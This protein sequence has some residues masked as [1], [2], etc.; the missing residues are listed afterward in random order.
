MTTEATAPSELEGA[1]ALLFGEYRESAQA[2]AD[3]LASSAVERGLIGPREVP[4]LWARHL[5]NCAAI[6]PLIPAGSSMVDVGS[7]AG[8][9]G[10]V[11]AIIRPDVSV[12]LLEPLQRRVSWLAEAVAALELAN[13]RVVR[14]RAESIR[15]G[16]GAEADGVPPRGFDVATARA[17]ASLGTLATWCLP[18]VRA[19]G[20]F[21]AIKGQ[22]AADELEAA[23]AVLRGLGATEWVVQS[24]GDG[25]LVEPTTAVVV[26]AGESAELAASSSGREGSAGRRS[27][28]QGAARGGSAGRGSTGDG[29]AGG[30]PRGRSG[31][32]GPAGRVGREPG[33]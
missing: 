19:G 16:A 22:S 7:G 17:V 13:V 30:R 12:T 8:L 28:R 9:P 3:L 4:R 10:L 24:C 11:L 2:Y 1:V 33:V 14:G 20:L 21:V 27:A 23:D 25:V 31:A 32:G 26:R 15:L 18:L 5:L 6:A 29:S